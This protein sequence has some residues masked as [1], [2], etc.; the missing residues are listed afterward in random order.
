[1]VND[2]RIRP[3]NSE[4]SARKYD[5]HSNSIRLAPDA[6]IVVLLKCDRL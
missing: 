3:L 6:E 5:S 1:M 4:P 2:G